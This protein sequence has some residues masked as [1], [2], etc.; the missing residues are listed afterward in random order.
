MSSL[1]KNKKVFLIG[2]GGIG[3]SAIAIILK[4][5]GYQV[6][7]SDKSESSTV[8]DLIKNGID[9]KIGHS[10][11][12][13]TDEIGTVIYTNAITDDN[14]EFLKAKKL[15]LDI[16]DRA[17]MLDVIAGSKF[18][19]GVSGTHGKTTTTSMIS[20]IF[21]NTGFEPSLAVGGYLNE[22]N[23]SGY[24]GNGKYFIYEACEA[25]GSFLKLHPN[26]AV[27]T[28]IDSDHL[29]YYKNIK[30]IKRAFGQY[31]LENIPP[32]GMLIYNRDDPNLNQVVEKAKPLRAISVGIR[33]KADFTAQS[34]E[35]ND[36]SSNIVV[37]NREKEV[38][39][40]TINIPGI[41]NV[42]NALL[43]IAAASV[44][45]VPNDD[46]YNTLA[47]FRNADRRFQL[48][49]NINNLMVIDD[50]AHHPSEIDATL[51][52]AKNLSVRKKAQLIA[53]FQP[54][55][56]SRTS[57]LYKDFAR[58]LSKAD[59]IVLT[60]IYASREKNENNIS[61]KMIYDEIVKI[62][63][64]E[65]VIYS[66]DLKDVPERVKHLL[67]G[68]NILITLGAGDVWK[69]SEMFSGKH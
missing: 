24:D 46:I 25:F 55:L 13:I 16:Y 57:L 26:I 19:I 40:F 22:I 67:N 31:I 61:T 12:N 36:F 64:I 49:L 15:N 39:A 5:R 1:N 45:G 47:N 4:K 8:R 28:N 65:N 58:S 50:Y 56:Y 69:V 11:E 60:E 20:K 41:H 18:T 27:I 34:I 9:V 35:L 48:K 10:D 6:S 43:A 51:K 52:A 33:N 7:G 42:Y 68:N 54:H 14:P 17:K 30:N 32:Y 44:N 53:V 62:K 38:G 59:R 3:M 2:I 23:G 37:R 66:K 21:L 63:G 29:D